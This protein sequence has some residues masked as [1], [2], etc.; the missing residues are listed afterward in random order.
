MN[1]KVILLVRRN[2]ILTSGKLGKEVLEI[3]LIK[4]ISVNLKESMTR[5]RDKLFGAPK[6][7]GY[8]RIFV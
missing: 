8:G 5:K 2:E 4:I 7:K 6:I 1:E 3:I